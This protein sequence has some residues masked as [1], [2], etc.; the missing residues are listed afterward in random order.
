MIIV[1]FSGVRVNIPYL[2]GKQ[3]RFN[4]GTALETMASIG[5][6]QGQCLVFT[7]SL[8]MTLW[9]LSHALRLGGFQKIEPPQVQRRLYKSVSD[10]TKFVFLDKRG[11]MCCFVE[12][13]IH[14]FVA[15]GAEWSHLN[16]QMSKDHVLA[17]I[18]SDP[19]CVGAR[20]SDASGPPRVPR[21][22]GAHVLWELI[23][24]DVCERS[25]MWLP[26][27]IRMAQ[28]PPWKMRRDH[29]RDSK[30][31]HNIYITS[32]QAAQRLRRWS[33]IA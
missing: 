29:P 21:V 30:H 19:C 28:Q 17:C 5:P 23:I 26:G 25:G 9:W 14:P 1:V 6:P 13:Q 16:I 18:R 27:L 8:T 15:K 24:P 33:N 7:G 32:A 4:V 2:L 20:V 22:S 3:H 12:W 10:F 11:C 31:L